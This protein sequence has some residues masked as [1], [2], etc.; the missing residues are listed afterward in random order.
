[1]IRVLH[2]QDFPAFRG[3]NIPEQWKP[4][5]KDSPI[6]DGEIGCYASHL[7]CM[8]DMLDTDESARVILGDDAVLSD[9]FPSCWKSFRLPP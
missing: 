3:A 5:F 9:N 6:G 1:M 4:Q 8:A 7:Q 2:L